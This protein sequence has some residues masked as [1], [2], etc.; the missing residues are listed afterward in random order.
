MKHKLFQ[1]W[2]TIYFQTNIVLSQGKFSS[3]PY[4]HCEGIFQ[5][6]VIFLQQMNLHHAMIHIL[7]RGIC[8]HASESKID[9][10]F[11]DNFIRFSAR[12]PCVLRRNTASLETRQ[13]RYL[14]Q[15]SAHELYR[16][17]CLCYFEWSNITK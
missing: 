3:F 8:L 4:K 12:P 6:L 1:L 7:F 2:S 10:T 11:K 16:V 9:N 5:N 15:W 17:I 14:T 13:Y